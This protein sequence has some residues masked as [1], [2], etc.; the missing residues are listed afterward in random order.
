MIVGTE[1]SAV[2]VATEL[3]KAYKRTT[4]LRSVDLEVAPGEVVGLLGPN[5]AGKS[6]LTKVLCGLVRPD[7]GTAAVA[8]AAAGRAPARAHTGYLAELFRFPGWLT[9]TEVLATHQR[10][11]RSVV[12]PAARAEREQLL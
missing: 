9:A 10:L 2:V 4:A 3:T 1:A 12:G 6:T 7:G 11:A 5:G 8:G